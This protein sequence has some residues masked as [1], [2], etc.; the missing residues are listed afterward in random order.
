M[1]A[2]ED[3]NKDPDTTPWYSQPAAKATYSILGV[4]IALAALLLAFGLWVLSSINSGDNDANK[5]TESGSETITTDGPDSKDNE[6]VNTQTRS[7]TVDQSELPIDEGTTVARQGETALLSKDS[8]FTRVIHGN[9]IKVDQIVQ[10]DIPVYIFAKIVSFSEDAVIRSP[11]IWIFAN[12]VTGGT[13]NVSGDNGTK[14]SRDGSHGGEVYILATSIRNLTIDADGGNGAVGAKG[15][16][17]RNGRDGSCAGFG[18]YRGAQRG[19]NGHQ[20]GV[21]G[22]GGNAGD[23]RVIYG[24]SEAGV[25]IN[26]KPGNGGSGGPGGDPGTG[27][28]G[29]IGLGGA[30]GD[31]GNGSHGSRGQPGGRGKDRQ[32]TKAKK[33][34]LV[35]DILTWLTTR[36]IRSIEALEYAHSS[37]LNDSK[38]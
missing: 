21:G 20:G 28:D 13:L 23:V 10:T 16:R 19:G 11:R 24:A 1:G 8:D 17:G 2:P 37:E 25:T 33:E 34:G 6:A 22:M 18:G 29:C 3:K 38:P 9:A 31:A 15:R 27:G 32:P 35:K 26:V 36:P 12:S 5:Y 4:G 30:Q 14:Q 7:K